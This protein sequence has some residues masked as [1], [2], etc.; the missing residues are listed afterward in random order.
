GWYQQRNDAKQAARSAA[1]RLANRPAPAR[2]GPATDRV[3][4]G[5]LAMRDGAPSRPSTSTP[6]RPA[7]QVGPGTLAGRDGAASHPSAGNPA[8]ATGKDIAEPE[9]PRN[10]DPLRPGSPDG[11]AASGTG[12]ATPGAG[13][14]GTGTPTLRT[15]RSDGTSD[16]GKPDVKGKPPEMKD[17]SDKSQLPP[18]GDSATDSSSNGN[19]GTS[20]RDVTA[21]AKAAAERKA[22]EHDIEAEL[23]NGGLRRANAADNAVA[24]LARILNADRATVRQLIDLNPYFEVVQNGRGPKIVAR[25]AG[26]SAPLHPD[27]LARLG[28][29]SVEDILAAIGHSETAALA[30]LAAARPNEGTTTDVA[31][32][33]TR[34]LNEAPPAQAALNR[35]TFYL[36]HAEGLTVPEIAALVGKSR[37]DV[38][39]RL[40][41]IRERIQRNLSHQLEPPVARGD[42]PIERANAMDATR[43]QRRLQPYIRDEM[44]KEAKQIDT[45]RGRHEPRGPAARRIEPPTPTSD[46]N[47]WDAP[48]MQENRSTIKAAYEPWNELAT[49]PA[50]QWFQ[51]ERAKRAELEERT[52]KGEDQATL[53]RD[54]IALTAEQTRRQHAGGGEHGIQLHP[55]Q[56]TAFLVMA[57]GAR[58][59]EVRRAFLKEASSKQG[60]GVVVD[61]LTGEGKT[62][63]WTMLASWRALNRDAQGVH[64]M[65]TKQDLVDRDIETYQQVLGEMHGRDAA[66]NQVFRI[67]R[68]HENQSE[69]EIRAA[70][71]APITYGTYS[72]FL[73]DRLGDLFTR[74]T[75][76]RVQR[77]HSNLIIDEIDVPTVQRGSNP[78]ILGEEAVGAVSRADA[79]YWAAQLAVDML[80]GGRST[81][82][83][84]VRARPRDGKVFTLRGQRA[85]KALARKQLHDGNLADAEQ[86]VLALLNH[87]KDSGYILTEDHILGI[88]D[89]LNGYALLSHKYRNG[90]QE[91]LHAK[92]GLPIGLPQRTL[93]Q[94]T[95]RDY[96]DLYDTTEG[97]TGTGKA[98]EEI[99]GDVFDM[100]VVQIPSALKILSEN[101]GYTTYL[102]RRGSEAGA[103]AAVAP[104]LRQGR[105]VLL[106]GFYV[107]TSER[108]GELLRS[109]HGI[110]AVVVNGRP[111]LAG[112]L[113]EVAANAGQI[114]A[115]TS[116]TLITARGTDIAI[117]EIVNEA[118]G[119]HE[120]NVGTFRTDAGEIQS[121]GR[122][123]RT[124]VRDGRQIRQRGSYETFRS[125]EDEVLAY[126]TPK[127]R[128][129]LDKIKKEHGDDPARA[130]DDPAL[131]EIFANAQRRAMEH[132]AKQ[133]KRNLDNPDLA[134]VAVVQIVEPNAAAESRS[135]QPSVQQR[136]AEGTRARELEDAY[137]A[138]EQARQE[139]QTAREAVRS[140]EEAARTRSVQD[141][142]DLSCSALCRAEANLTTAIQSY[143]ETVA[144][145]LSDASGAG[146]GREPGNASVDDA[147]ASVD[148][149]QSMVDEAAALAAAGG[150]ARSSSALTRM[151]NVSATPVRQA[152]ALLALG[153]VTGATTVLQRLIEDLTVVAQRDGPGW[154]FSGRTVD[155]ARRAVAM[156]QRIAG[157]QEFAASTGSQAASTFER[158][159][160][161]GLLPVLR[162]LAASRPTAERAGELLRSGETSAAADALRAIAERT[163]RSAGT[164]APAA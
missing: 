116:S 6:A 152:Q 38:Q 29:Q 4:P 81:R 135:E 153:S 161:A 54:H 136:G 104:V 106:H 134:D 143:R 110:E 100:E 56:M 131:D 95:I 91:A 57:K 99:F 101:R 63:V 118:G 30:D 41:H 142:I 13:D 158:R 69:Q 83:R 36:R 155:A 19:H 2:T 121:N 90:L 7:A 150:P 85:V 12:S 25:M 39:A 138:V 115:V 11:T 145:G 62:R 60:R 50:E 47:Y 162:G 16:A 75:E 141:E 55:V 87:H 40:G 124:A 128:Q 64:V 66:G 79:H 1:N 156:L 102:T 73:F 17:D 59:R 72:Q 164:S 139:F 58:L 28:S 149:V 163:A 132:D 65:T 33:I 15:E 74:S 108:I 76:Q 61:V 22:L 154:V 109:E 160:L 70:Y 31:T 147:P 107:A 42:G 127:D 105:P 8:H 117:N 114:G 84:Y 103:A 123:G 93:G 119:L 144:A 82:Y 125:T 122:T 133:L 52:A 129:R 20:V 53:L 111:E 14:P 37:G 88:M 137:D 126:L 112:L 10:Q 3:G 27:E 35:T 148:A 113:D 78:H 120:I 5:T 98:H 23:R 89:N 21:A 45:A 71:E 86:A 97:A 9:G 96:M 18:P 26:G 44:I 51:V 80:V 92:H 94:I 159:Q 46:H 67:G 24:E 157:Q 151:P 32:A 140:G 49:V 34:A 68:R 77:G 146:A 130:L 48:V 43:E